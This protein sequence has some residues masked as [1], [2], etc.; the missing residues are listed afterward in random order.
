LN[1]LEVTVVSSAGTTLF[2]PLPAAGAI[3]T[4][5]QEHAMAPRDPYENPRSTGI[6]IRYGKFRFL[7]VGDLS[8]QPLFNLACPKSLIGPVDAYWVAHRGRPDGD[9]PATF[10]AFKPRLALMNT[11]LKKAGPLATCQLL[12][13][14]PGSKAV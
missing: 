6:V 5:C 2:G 4:A 1:D 3:T 7:D 10:A 11:G 13:H 8:G 14:V 9:V 12:H